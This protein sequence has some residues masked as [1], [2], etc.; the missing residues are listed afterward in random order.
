M[1]CGICLANLR[2]K[3]QCFGC[4]SNFVDGIL[5]F[6]LDEFLLIEQ[7]KW[8]CIKCGGTICVHEGYCSECQK[9]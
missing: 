2:D 8:T 3:N 9:D 1:N 6:G 4:R 7:L 5:K